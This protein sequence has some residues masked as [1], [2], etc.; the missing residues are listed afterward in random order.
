MEFLRKLFFSKPD[1]RPQAPAKDLGLAG[2]I[3][4]DPAAFARWVLDDSILCVSFEDDLAVSPSEERVEGWGLPRS[5]VKNFANEFAIWRTV[6][7]IKFLRSFTPERFCLAARRALTPEVAERIVRNAPR[8]TLCAVEDIDAAIDE[9]LEALKSDDAIPFTM[10]YA[11]RLLSGSNAN[12]LAFADVAVKWG[13]G[14]IH[15]T[16]KRVFDRHCQ[17]KTG[18]TADQLNSMLKAIEYAEQASPD[19]AQGKEQ[20]E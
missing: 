8:Y 15:E 11:S 13:V 19:E 3:V 16:Y 5:A 10:T 14:T 18:F 2:R 7:A 4:S 9:Y 17:L 1:V 20:D 6:G 12:P